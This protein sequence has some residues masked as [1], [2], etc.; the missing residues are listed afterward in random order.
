M[1]AYVVKK[2][3][4]YRPMVKSDTSTW[5][6]LLG[7]VLADPHYGSASSIDVLL[8]ADIHAK[9]VG[10]EVIKG[11]A[12][13]PIATKT[14]LG[15]LLSGETTSVPDT[16]CPLLNVLH[17]NIQPELHEMLQKFWLQEEIVKPKPDSPEEVA[18][19]E[20]FRSTFF[21]NK[22][23]RYFTRLPSKSI[24]IPSLNDTLQTSLKMLSNV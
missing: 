4:S 3:T 2:V 16:D 11:Q 1:G 18:C 8:G 5:N 10:G 22:E 24:E 14:K 9:I 7:L 15:W 12:Y 23:G 20:H 13:T 17:C 19:E 21:R 6:H